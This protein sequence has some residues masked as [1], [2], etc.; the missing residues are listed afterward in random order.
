MGVRASRQVV[1]L[2][3]VPD[4]QQELC[5]LLTARADK[6]GSVKERRE[7]RA[8][9]IAKH[10]LL[11]KKA[12][13][14]GR[15]SLPRS[16]S[17]D[18]SDAT[19]P[20]PSATRRRRG[21]EPSVHFRQSEETFDVDQ[22]GSDVDV[23]SPP[24]VLQK[25]LCFAPGRDSRRLRPSGSDL[26]KYGACFDPEGLKI[27]P[28]SFAAGFELVN[29]E[30]GT[31]GCSTVQACRCRVTGV[32]F[33]VKAIALSGED[34]PLWKYLHRE[35]RIL[36]RLR[37]PGMLAL[38]RFFLT[39]LEARLVTDLYPGGTLTSHLLACH[40]SGG[41]GVSV[42]RSTDLIRQVL[43]VVAFLHSH[44]VVHRDVKPDNLCLDSAR[45]D[46]GLKL[47]DFG[48]ATHC[49]DDQ[50]L[51]SPCGTFEFM[52]GEMLNGGGYAFPVDVWACGVTYYAICTGRFPRVAGL[53]ADRIKK[54]R[55][56]EVTQADLAPLVAQATLPTKA[57]TRLLRRLL[58]VDPSARA[59]A[60]GALEEGLFLPGGDAALPAA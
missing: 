58:A 16:R 49:S 28:G 8:N 20:G 29:K 36:Q 35:V 33:A 7:R 50:L 40:A 34:D 14:S 32:E 17:S 55:H 24:A 44:R 27:E 54:G 53:V 38:R 5:S 18:R 4:Q 37:H 31:G 10:L 11:D 23:P 46:A 6:R 30:L 2:A 26:P 15:S 41:G 25:S 9:E 13:A 60:A 39:K 57:Q 48:F 59:T 52:A 19:S 47:I 42:A 22:R 43:A 45:P 51:L 21:S 3:V 12:Q 1:P 56:K